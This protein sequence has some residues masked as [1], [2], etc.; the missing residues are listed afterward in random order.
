MAAL[1]EEE[2]LARAQ[3]LSGN[4]TPWE[5]WTA[6]AQESWLEE[7]RWSLIVE[8]RDHAEEQA[9]EINI[10]YDTLLKDFQ[11]SQGAIRSKNEELATRKEELQKYRLKEAQLTAERNASIQNA[12]N[13]GQRNQ[14]LTEHNEYLLSENRRLR[15]LPFFRRL[16]YK[17]EQKAAQSNEQA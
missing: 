14:K 10:A 9:H 4:N 7:A 11:L 2:I 5:F 1:S 16:L 13:I 12:I 8:Q 15:S 17:R 3:K 6:E